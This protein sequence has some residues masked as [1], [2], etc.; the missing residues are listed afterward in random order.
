MNRIWYLFA[1][2]LADSS[3]AGRAGELNE[4][5]MVANLSGQ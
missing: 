3:Q 5:S 2:P 1:H 4:L